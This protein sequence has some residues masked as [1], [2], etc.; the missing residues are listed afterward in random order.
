MAR[1]VATLANHEDLRQSVGEAAR[2]YVRENLSSEACTQ[3][4]LDLYKR[5]ISGDFG[6]V[7]PA[8]EPV[9]LSRTHR[10]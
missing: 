3:A 7:A 8:E 9:E 1:L 6:R 2:A 10:D 5:L 4:F